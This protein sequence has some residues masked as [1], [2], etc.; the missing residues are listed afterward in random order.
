ME[1]EA[2]YKLNA[3]VLGAITG[4]I[5]LIAHNDSKTCDYEM[6]IWFVCFTIYCISTAIFLFVYVKTD[7]ITDLWYSVSGYPLDVI[8]IGLFVFGF[9]IFS[10]LS[11]KWAID[12]PGPYYIMLL[13]LIIQLATFLKYISWGI[14][15]CVCIP[16]ILYAV[17]RGYRER[18]LQAQSAQ[19]PWEE[20]E[21][22]V[23]VNLEEKSFN[24]EIQSIAEE[25][26]ICMEDFKLGDK[27]I[28]LPWNRQH[29][30]HKD[31]IKQWF[32]RRHTCPL[33]KQNLEEMQS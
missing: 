30:F 14:L 33:C 1:T 31:W 12:Y 27:V 26:W 20:F 21:R 7:H 13:I 4:L 25:C 19:A 29:H 11:E 15:I 2:S 8:T 32:I 16:I 10:N 17:F 6:V 24:S 28:I 22:N 18:N 23:F 3:N 9:I 5:V